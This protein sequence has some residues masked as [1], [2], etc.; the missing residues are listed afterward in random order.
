MADGAAEIVGREGDFHIGLI[1]GIV[2][3]DDFTV[4]LVV[5]RYS[6]GRLAGG[7]FRVR[8]VLVV[9]SAV[10]PLFPAARLRGHDGARV[11]PREVAS[12]GGDGG[13]DLFLGSCLVPGQMCFD[14]GHS[15]W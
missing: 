11:P 9:L 10:A 13:L 5:A 1:V 4:I 15:S 8:R 12:C 7:A 14:V 6:A 2:R 3:P